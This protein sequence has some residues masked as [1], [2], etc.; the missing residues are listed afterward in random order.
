MVRQTQE[1]GGWFEGSWFS[2]NTITTIVKD[3]PPSALTTYTIF[4]NK[5]YKYGKIISF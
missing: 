4:K 1:G 2:F 3:A 5:R